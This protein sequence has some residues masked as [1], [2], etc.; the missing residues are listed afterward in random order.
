MASG[1]TYGKRN[2]LP[3]RL[4]YET[5][6]EFDRALGQQNPLHSAELDLDLSQFGG[7][8]C[9]NNTSVQVVTGNLPL[10]STASNGIQQP[11]PPLVKHKCRSKP[12]QPS[13]VR[14]LYVQEFE[15]AVDTVKSGRK[16]HQ[17]W[18]GSFFFF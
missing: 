1:V 9:A 18:R 10:T 17:Q 14:K 12:N 5:S 11:E 7:I 13:A 16:E 4:D 6:L 15:E 3:H 2:P 8:L